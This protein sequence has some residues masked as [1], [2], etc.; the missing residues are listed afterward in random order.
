M[1]IFWRE[2]LRGTWAVLVYVDPCTRDEL[3]RALTEILAHPISRPRV[4]LLIDRRHCRA[5]SATFVRHI[6]AF[7]EAR[8]DRFTA[9][10]VAIVTSDEVGMGAA[11]MTQIIGESKGIPCALAA[12]REWAE[13]E[14]WLQVAQGATGR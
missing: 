5:P 7:M 4:R 11:Q 6:A 12:F 3:S 2:G 8:I 9:G 10:H 13:A 1:P 14:Q